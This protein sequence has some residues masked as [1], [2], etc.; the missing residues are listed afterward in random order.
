MPS[1]N[2]IPDLLHMCAP[3]SE[4]PSDFSTMIKRENRS[5]PMKIFPPNIYGE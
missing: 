1:T 5:F 3:C 4:L 2:G